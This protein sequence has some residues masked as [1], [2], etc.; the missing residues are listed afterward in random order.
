MLRRTG[1]AALVIALILIV[2]ATVA[3]AAPAS[4]GKT[5]TVVERATTDTVVDLGAAGDTIGDMLVFGND[6]YDS[7]N[8][9]K[10]DPGR[11]G[12]HC[13]GPVLRRP[14]RLAA[15]DH[16]WDRRLRECPRGD[17]PPRARRGGQ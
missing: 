4:R 3:S 2:G 10:V 9:T 12:D 7:A 15:L 17:D 13:A 8:T 11:R 6:V 16:R 5:L 14:A 1:T